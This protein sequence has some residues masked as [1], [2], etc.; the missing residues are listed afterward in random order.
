MG[1]AA[2]PGGHQRVS[3]HV[4]PKAQFRPEIDED[5]K[6]TIENGWEEEASTTVEGGEVADKVRA[7]GTDQPQRSVITRRTTTGGVSAD[8][9]GFAC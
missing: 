2:N 8:S 7:L 4:L 5:E 1:R 3:A 6:T 9:I